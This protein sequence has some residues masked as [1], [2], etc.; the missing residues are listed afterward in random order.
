MNKFGSRS[1]AQLTTCHE[2]LVKIHHLAIVR[3]NVDYGIHQGG[4]TVLEQQSYFDDGKSKIN[5]KNYPTT[6]SLAAKAKHIIIPGHNE[7]GR[8]RA[9]DMHIAEKYKGTSLTWDQ[10]HLSYVAGVLISCAQELYNNG[11]ICNLLR[12][13]ADWDSDGIIGLDH[14]LRDFPHVELI[15]P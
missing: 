3:S 11:E 7:F 5:P 4:R 13:G 15:N 6:E 12:W 14:S 10:S 1:L 9:S 2:D 8:S